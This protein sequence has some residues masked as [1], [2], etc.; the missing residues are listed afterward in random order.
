MYAVVA[1]VEKYPEFLP[2]VAGLRVLSRGRDGPVEILTAEM[3][4][5]Y[6]GLRERYT[7]RVRLDPQSKTIEA[8]AIEGPFAR[9][10]NRWRFESADGLC[11]VHFSV[12]FAFKSRLL[13]LVANAA[14]AGAVTKMAD[15]FEARAR[16]SQ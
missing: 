1:D 11:H 3:M 4:V 15:A 12:G 2:W 16:I 10:D 6:R 8:E 7:S 14:F 9:L 5:A 13:N